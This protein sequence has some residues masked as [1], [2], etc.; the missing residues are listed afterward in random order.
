MHASAR[1]GQS[2]LRG[3]V[4]RPR[5]PRTSCRRPT[6]SRTGGRSPRARGRTRSA[7]RTA[8]FYANGW[9]ITGEMG[10]IW[11]PP[12]KLADGVWFGVDD[13]WV[14]A[15]TKFTSGRGYVALRRCRRSTGCCCAAPTSSPTAAA[16]RSSGSSWPTRGRGQD[17]HG[18]G[19]RALR[20]ARRLP[21]VGAR[22]RRPPPTTS[23]TP[24]RFDDGALVFTDA[25]RC[26]APR[27]TTTRRWSLHARPTARPARATAA[28]SRA[29]S[30]RTATSRRRAPAT[31]ARTARAPAASCATR[32]RVARARPRDG[33]DRGRRLRARRRDARAARRCATRTPSWR[34]RSR[35]R[36]R[37]PRTRRSTCPATAAAE[38]GR[39]GQAEPRRPHADRDRPEDPLRRPGQG[40][41]RAGRP[42]QARDVL[43]RRLPRLPVA[44]RHRRRV[45]GVRRPSRS[46]SSRRSSTHLIALRD[47]SD[48]L[49]ASPAR[50]RTR[51]SP[52]ARSTSAPTPTP[53]TPTSRPSS[54]ARSRWSGA[55][56]ATTASATSS[57]TS[58][59]RTLRYVADKLD[60][61]KDGWPEGLGNVERDGMGAGEARQ[62]R[63]PDPRPLRPRRHGRGQGR[64]RDR[65]VGDA[66]SP[67]SCAARFDATWWNA[68][69]IQYADS[70]DDRQRADPAAALDRRHADGGRA[71]VGR[72][73]RRASR[74]PSTALTALAERE[75]DCFSG[76]RPFNLGLF[77]TGCEGGPKGK[78]ERM[79]FSLTTSIAGRRRGQLRPARRGPAAALHGRQRRADVRRHARRAA[80]RAAGDPA[81]ARP[82]RATSTAAGPAARCSCRPGAS[83]A[84]P[85]R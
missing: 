36:A 6:G 61:D 63:L 56:R 73:P 78:G 72:L 39:L 60:A 15:A 21:V 50:S 28:R 62:R 4:R 52:T 59:M 19:R 31:T 23:P 11:A 22:P 25:A 75:N 29:R 24:R 67:T 40:L 84:S 74:R 47:V 85:G 38:R 70:L 43:R 41:S 49:N 16:P 10:G 45:H 17:R 9:H 32:S 35:P 2:A 46:A 13:Q 5:R 58:P 34:P 65:E 55:G 69:S 20:A 57:T 80:R 33:L 7:S 27:P 68:E 30:A 1:A 53:A 48:A 14:G 3:A 83:T 66:A 54:R 64:P 44:V 26:P 82:G 51:S 12:L 79:I 71:D 81:V 37:S 8:R 42:G 77:H 18:Q 76:T